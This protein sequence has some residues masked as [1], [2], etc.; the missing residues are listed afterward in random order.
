MS[1]WNG[2]ARRDGVLVVQSFE[3]HWFVLPRDD[4]PAIDRCPSC[5]R[6]L[7]TAE[8]ARAV[9]D[10]VLPLREAVP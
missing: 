9:A 5:G 7:Q 1:A 6:P 10:H 2:N 4:R 3:S 8:E